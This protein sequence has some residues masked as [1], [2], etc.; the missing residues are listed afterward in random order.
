M[1]ESYYG[2]L[3]QDEDM[4]QALNSE[5]YVESFENEV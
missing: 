4:N 3:C 5:D 1:P 2:V